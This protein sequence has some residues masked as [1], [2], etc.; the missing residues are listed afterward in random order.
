MKKTPLYDE[1]VKLGARIV[2]FNGWQMPV[3]YTNVIDEH[4]RTRTKAALFDISHMGEFMIEGKDA[5]PF[6]QKVL[7]KD[8]SKINIRRCAY[9]VMCNENGGTIDDLFVYCLDDNRFMLVTNAGT[10]EKDHIH[11]VKNRKDM[12]VRIANI[13]DETTKLDIQGPESEKILQ[14]LTETKLAE[15]KRFDF[16]EIA[17]NNIGIMISRSGYT[18]E[19]GFEIYFNKNKAIEIWNIL[20]ETG[21]EHGLKPAG[22]GARDTLR[23]E[24]C[25][26]LYGHEINENTSPIEAGIP[27]TI[28][29]DKENFIGKE[30]LINTKNNQ[31]KKLIAFELIEKGIPRQNYKV[32]KDNKEIGYVTSGTL[33]PTLKKGI[34]LA[35]INIEFANLETEID[36]NIR[37]KLYKAKIVKKPFYTYNGK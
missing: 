14:K 37:D 20:L 21:K 8:I 22:L 36:I 35:L 4:T 23:L 29:F 11:L 9:T 1:H 3:M 13:S 19:D 7:A 32:L 33:S 18:G 12:D 6:L 34:G 17:L 28:S 5:T 26:S 2:D 15:I 24:C 10:I 27:F 16:K 31:K 25:Y 30:A